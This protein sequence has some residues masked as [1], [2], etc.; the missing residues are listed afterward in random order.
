M[1]DV[2]QNVST[3]CK[4]HYSSCHRA[5]SC[6]KTVRCTKTNRDSR[7]L[8][9]EKHNVLH[10][11]CQIARA[12]NNQISLC[13][14]SKANVSRSPWGKISSGEKDLKKKKKRE[15]QSWENTDCYCYY[16]HN[17]SCAY[18]ASSLNQ[19]EIQFHL[20][21]LPVLTG[22]SLGTTHLA[23]MPKTQSGTIT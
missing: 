2:W 20:M 12:A 3:T 19:D 1:S 22:S 23:G 4:D 16:Y 7:H 17:Y 9:L 10:L 21:K 13:I 8:G 11:I 6:R 15:Q 14:L 18:H 5:R